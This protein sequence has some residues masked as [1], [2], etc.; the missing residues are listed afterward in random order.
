MANQKQDLQI[1]LA[2]EQAEKKTMAV[3]GQLAELIRHELR[4]H[5]AQLVKQAA[6]LTKLKA[7]IAQWAQLQ[8]R[9]EGTK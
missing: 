1:S 6:E 7:E 9:T 4:M 5:D 2:V 3:V 8:Q